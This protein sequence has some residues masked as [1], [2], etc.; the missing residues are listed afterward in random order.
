MTKEQP[1][2]IFLLKI[3]VF[4]EGRSFLSSAQNVKTFEEANI[5]GKNRRPFWRLTAFEE[6]VIN[7]H[8]QGNLLRQGFADCGRSIEL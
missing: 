1:I 7:R 8:W 3:L 5:K 4:D 2:L 6:L